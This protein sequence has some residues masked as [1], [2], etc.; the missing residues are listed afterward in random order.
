M[1]DVVK[2]PVRLPLG[3][4]MLA[5]PEQSRIHG[6]RFTQEQRQKMLQL[7]FGEQPPAG[8]PW[9][10]RWSELRAQIEGATHTRMFDIVGNEVK[11]SCKQ[12]ASFYEYHRSRRRQT[13]SQGYLLSGGVVKAH[14]LVPRRNAFNLFVQVL[15]AEGGTRADARER[16]SNL[17]EEEKQQWRLKAA[18]A[19]MEDSQEGRERIFK[20]AWRSVM[21]SIAALS[22]I[23]V[24][25]IAVA[26]DGVS[27]KL[28]AS[29]ADDL[30]NEYL[31]QLKRMPTDF[32]LLEHFCGWRK[33]H[34]T[35]VRLANITHAA[36]IQGMSDPSA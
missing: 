19:V 3:S 17:P 27:A 5:V 1:T 21:R 4:A 8:T 16:W 35:A 14:A 31:A 11:L 23:G 9:A 32:D 28:T 10:L 34:D 30:G 20:T 2:T 22:E 25:A 15:C 6:N 26:T 29:L 24:S 33:G 12:V 36:H 13:G 18:D 7:L